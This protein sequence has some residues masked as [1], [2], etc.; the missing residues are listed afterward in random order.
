M[1]VGHVLN[2][3]L[4][5]VL[6]H[7]IIGLVTTVLQKPSSD[8]SN[9]IELSLEKCSLDKEIQDRK[10]NKKRNSTQKKLGDDNKGVQ[11]E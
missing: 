6:D 2:H 9:F 7:M 5:H 1:L 8:K 4:V 3:V 10:E 11:L